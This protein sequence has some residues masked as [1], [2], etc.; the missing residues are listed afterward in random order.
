MGRH[1]HPMVDLG[2]VALAGKS[3][4]LQRWAVPRRRTR[5]QAPLT[6]ARRTGDPA[7]CG[8]RA[9]PGTATFPERRRST[10][11]GG[12]QVTRCLHGKISPR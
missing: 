4:V 12:G 9:V 3:R 5:S 2:L 6:C 1:P 11:P 10:S 7:I 8:L